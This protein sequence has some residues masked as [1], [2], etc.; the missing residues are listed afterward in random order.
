[1]YKNLDERK[2]VCLVIRPILMFFPRNFTVRKTTLRWFEHEQNHHPGDQ[3]TGLVQ[4]ASQKCNPT[5]E[6]SSGKRG[7][8]RKGGCGNGMANRRSSQ[9]PV[10]PDT[11]R[12]Q[13][14]PYYFFSKYFYFLFYFYGQYLIKSPEKYCCNLEQIS[15]S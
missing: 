7:K 3:N 2:V 10:S 8:G 6:F 4:E 11:A 9:A 1:M 5:T 15:S 14:G 13:V 12:K